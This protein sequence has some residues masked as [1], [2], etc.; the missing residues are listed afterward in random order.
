[1]ETGSRQS[2]PEEHACCT[3][4]DPR[5]SRS[6]FCLDDS[7]RQFEKEA[8]HGTLDTGRYRCSYYVWGS[9]PPLLFIHGAGDIAR[10]FI[11]VISLLA[12]HCRCI[13]YDLPS[14][15]NDGARLKEYRHPDLVAD[16]FCLLDHLSAPRAYVLGSSFGS[17]IA[18]A[19]MAS[20]PERI[21]R[22]VLSGAFACRGLA[23]LELALARA[24]CY[25]PGSMSDLP[26][27]RVAARRA[28]DAP[29]SS[30]DELRRF[31]LESTGTSP[32]RALA[33]RAL[34]VHKLDLR[35]ILRE[36]H[37]PVLIINGDCDAVVS[38]SCQ[39]DLLERLPNAACVEIKNCGHMAHYTHPREMAELIAHFLTPPSAG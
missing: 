3:R 38:R 25:L 31:G 23:S 10:G 12:G 27:R 18:L 37:Q 9:G 39:A 8:T 21:P 24:A 22:A 17:T 26:F 19:A 15:R 6:S 20:R 29:D 16:L 30:P 32:V 35:G 11:P 33:H 28:F 34:I 5:S 1:M 2:R 36:I 14:G 4:A 13:A 7:L